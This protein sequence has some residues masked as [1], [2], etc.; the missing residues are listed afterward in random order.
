VAVVAVAAVVVE[1]RAMAA[2]V[3]VQVV[4]TAEYYRLYLEDT[5]KHLNKLIQEYE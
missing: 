1:V 4:T 3:A 2:V 5:A